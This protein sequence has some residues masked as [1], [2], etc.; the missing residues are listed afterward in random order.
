MA[1][2]RSA[3]ADGHLDDATAAPREVLLDF[4]AKL[5]QDAAEALGVTLFPFYG[6]LL[7]AVRE[8][9]FLSQDGDFDTAYIS[10]HSDPD[11]VRHQFKELCHHLLARGYNIEAE[12]THA[13]LS[14][15]GTSERVAVYFAWFTRT[16]EFDASYGYHGTPVQRSAD[17]FEFRTEKLGDVEVAVPANAE[18]ILTQLYGTGWR[19]PDPD[20]VQDTPAR[21]HDNAYLLETGD[22]TEL[23]WSQ[24]YRDH[25]PDR[26]SRF[27]EFVADRFAS[28]GAVVEFGCGSGRD[29]IYFA[30]RGWAAFS[31]DRSPEAIARAEEVLQ[32][33]GGLP[34]RFAA[35]DAGSDHEVR[36]FLAGHKDVLDDADPLLVYMR[37]FLHAI[38]EDAQNSLL[39]TLTAAI[40]R[41]FYLCAEFRTVADRDLTKHHGQHY[42][43]YIDHEQLADQLRDRWG[44][45]VEHLEAGQGLSPY[46]DE[47]PFLGRIVARRT[48]TR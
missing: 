17:F 30:H 28:P 44:F 31:C 16:G 42:R 26:A 34:A 8:Q 10:E 3:F 47:D 37:F 15:P 21:K 7:G 45:D 19:T 29:G 46:D 18:M 33:S 39:D 9:S 20:F 2:G 32:A 41:D 11:A 36:A 25:E 40:T 4:Y 1:D 12:T 5:H 48:D 43:R 27:A 6:T 13:W 35:V 23:H 38:D 24:F 14:V 22:V